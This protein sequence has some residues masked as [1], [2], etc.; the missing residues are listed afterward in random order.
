MENEAGRD[1]GKFS[2]FN[3]ILAATA[4]LSILY[5]IFD[6]TAIT[7]R[8]ANPLVRDIIV[9]VVLLF[10]L[11]EASRRVIG[12]ALGVIAIAFTL[13]AF[14]G[15]H[16]PFVFAF[17]G[18]SLRRFLSQITLSTQGIYG[19]PLYV[20]AQTVFLFVLLGSMLE[21]VGAGHFF[22]DLALSLLGRFK[23][24]PAKA[25]RQD[26]WVERMVGRAGYAS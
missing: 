7:M 12:P 18:I 21:R 13:Y 10:L 11:L 4:G 20:S 25:A 15:P 2:I 5:F 9:S 22:N 23:G 17:R 19:I 24:G 3:Y 8:E 1:S 16:M 14:L 6:W 26:D